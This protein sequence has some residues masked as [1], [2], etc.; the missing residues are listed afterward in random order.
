VRTLAAREETVARCRTGAVGAST[1]QLHDGWRGDSRTFLYGGRPRF[2]SDSAA[3]WSGA[4]QLILITRA[5]PG[6]V[7]RTA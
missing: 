4:D 5:E 2:T 7:G 6:T 1:R 3:S